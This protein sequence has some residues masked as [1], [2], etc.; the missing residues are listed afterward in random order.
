MI[1]FVCAMPRE[2]RPLRR[3][4]GLHRTESG[5]IGRVGEHPTIAIVTGIGTAQA[6][7]ATAQ[8]ATAQLL[9]TVKVEWVIVV[10]ISGAIDNQTPIG[11][12]VLPELVVSGADCS[13]YRPKPL[14]LGDAH[15]TLWTTDSLLVDPR[16]HADLRNR[17]VVSLDMETAAIAKVCE[18]R[19]VPWSVLRAVSD[20]ASDGS[21]DAEILGLANPDGRANSPAAARYLLRHPG[22]WLRLVR[23]ARG[24]KLAS[25]RAAEAAITAVS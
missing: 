20:R 2:L 6:H 25:E 18:Q 15:G 5:Y 4:L 13:Q 8:A 7:A 23:L 14:R 10:G 12:L 17:G 9:D 1:A 16:V 21:V 24:S 22:A 19:G 3:R 11:T